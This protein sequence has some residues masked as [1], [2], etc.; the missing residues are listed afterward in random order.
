MRACR[1][2][3]CRKPIDPSLGLWVSKL[4]QMRADGADN[5]H[6]CVLKTKDQKV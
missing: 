6:K 4:V 3:D 1:S 5:F 2:E